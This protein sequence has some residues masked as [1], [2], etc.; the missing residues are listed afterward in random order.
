MFLSY[1]I[2][3]DMKMM[4]LIFTAHVHVMQN[5]D[6]QKIFEQML[7]GPPTSICL[8]FWLLNR[9][10][11]DSKR[12]P[13]QR[14]ANVKVL[15]DKPLS[16]LPNSLL[17]II[18]DGIYVFDNVSVTKKHPNVTNIS[19]DQISYKKHSL[20]AAPTVSMS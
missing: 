18:S 2:F 13:A 8:C 3:C 1:S 19:A 15:V 14:S 5:F 17:E 11:K 20:H 16:V 6:S 10:D 4:P 7:V 9:E 12:F